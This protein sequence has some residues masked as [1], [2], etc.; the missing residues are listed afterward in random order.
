MNSKDFL[1]DLETAPQACLFIK[2]LACVV[3]PFMRTTLLTVPELAA[4][5]W[6]RSCCWK[7]SNL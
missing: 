6:H 7:V 2:L 1:D 5:S 3:V 4:L